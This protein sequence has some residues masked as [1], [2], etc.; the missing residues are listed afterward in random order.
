MV[1]DAVAYHQVVCPSGLSFTARKYKGREANLFT[2][3]KLVRAGGLITAILDAVCIEVT[4]PGPYTLDSNNR[5]P[6][7]RMLTGD[8]IAS[9]VETRVGTYGPEISFPVQCE[10]EV[11]RER[12]IE[13]LDL[14][15]DLKRK[16]LTDEDRN[17]YVNGNEFTTYLIDGDGTKREVK[18]H[19]LTGQDERDLLKLSRRFKD[20]QATASVLQRIN[21]VE[22]IHKNDLMKLLEELDLDEMTAIV[23]RM[24]AHDCGLETTIE[25]ECPECSNYQELEVPLG[26]KEFFMPKRKKDSRTTAAAS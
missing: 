1:A 18:Y 24:D 20:K 7:D 9:L 3:K 2:D 14:I 8:R 5:P 26:G 21:S 12:W 10:N 25:V 15:R 17:T 22:Q 6:W 19:L 13:D 23:D 4:D 11:C 16:V